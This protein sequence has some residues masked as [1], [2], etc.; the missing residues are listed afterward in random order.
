[1]TTFPIKAAFQCC[2]ALEIIYLIFKHH[3]EVDLETFMWEFPR[4]IRRRL[5]P[6]NM[7]GFSPNVSAFELGKFGESSAHCPSHGHMGLMLFFT[8]QQESKYEIYYLLYP[9]GSPWHIWGNKQELLWHWEKVS[10]WQRNPLQ[11][12]GYST[13]AVFCLFLLSGKRIG[14]YLTRQS[15]WLPRSPETSCELWRRECPLPSHTHTNKAEVF[16]EL[17]TYFSVC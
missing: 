17:H 5:S 6:G 9:T 1:M 14:M 3:T 4:S 15:M 7:I 10:A 16:T 13:W 12:C 2:K 11:D 8:S